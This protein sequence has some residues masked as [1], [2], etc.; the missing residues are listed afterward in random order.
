MT[1]PPTTGPTT[2]RTT[3]SEVVTL[4][5]CELELKGGFCRLR[6]F[7]HPVNGVRKLHEWR[8]TVNTLT[9]GLLNEFGATVDELSVAALLG[10][11]GIQGQLAW[12]L[13]EAS[14][15]HEGRGGSSQSV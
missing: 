5:T 7:G 2:S 14:G 9:A 3:P 8:F 10:A 6:A 12:E 13:Y 1:M 4:V 15:S 11:V